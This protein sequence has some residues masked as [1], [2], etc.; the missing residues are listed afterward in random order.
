MAFALCSRALQIN[1]KN[2]NAHLEL[3]KLY[4]N[5]GRYNRAIVMWQQGLKYHPQETMFVDFIQEAERLSK[6]K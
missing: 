4:G 3:G 2:K 1:P 6:E 5:Q